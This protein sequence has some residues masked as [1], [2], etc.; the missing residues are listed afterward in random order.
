MPSQLR[1]LGAFAN[2]GHH[3]CL[4]RPCWA[5]IYTMLC[6]NA[7]KRTQSK[8]YQYIIRKLVFRSVQFGWGFSGQTH[9]VCKIQHPKMHTCKLNLQQ[10]FLNSDTVLHCFAHCGAAL[11]GAVCDCVMW[12]CWCEPD[13]WTSLHFLFLGS[14]EGQVVL[15]TLKYPN[16]LRLN[17][18]GAIYIVPAL[19]LLF[20]L[21]I[22]N[23]D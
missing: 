7:Y 22:S 5:V 6:T 8:F 21:N 1:I 19:L 20:Y 14:G 16:C 23:I 15:V 4:A 11:L 17:S 12:S 3:V 18:S 9:E 2:C 10:T 13:F